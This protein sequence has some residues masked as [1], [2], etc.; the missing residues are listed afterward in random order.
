MQHIFFGN[1]AIIKPSQIVF[2]NKKREIP[3]DIKENK[4]GNPPKSGYKHSEESDNASYQKRRQR[5]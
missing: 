2:R 1:C 3:L 4:R 5:S